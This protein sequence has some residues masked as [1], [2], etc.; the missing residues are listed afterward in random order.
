MTRVEVRSKV[1]PDGVLRLDVPLGA[2]E[3]NREVRV[4]VEDVTPRP[5][6]RFNSQEEYA[7]WVRS[8]AGSITDAGFERPE[9][10]EYEER[11]PL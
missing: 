5:W 6:G 10:G 11:D 2:S 3:A 1:G 9:Q 4:I 7:E 8:I